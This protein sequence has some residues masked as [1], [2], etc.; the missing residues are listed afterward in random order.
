MSGRGGGHLRTLSWLPVLCRIATAFAAP[1]ADVLIAGDAAPSGPPAIGVAIHYTLPSDGPLPATF[2]VTLAITDAHDADWVVS[3]FVRGATRTVTAE[4]K[5]E[6]TEI[7]DGLDENLM[8]VPPGSYGV[9]GIRM[10]ARRWAPDGDYHTL[11][12]RYLGGP[13]SF[14]PSAAEADKPPKVHGD[15]VGSV[16]GAISTPQDWSAHATFYWHYLENGQNTYQ[17]DLAKPVGYGQISGSYGSGGAGGGSACCTDGEMTWSLNEDGPIPYLYRA[18]AKPFGHGAGHVRRNVWVTRGQLRGLTCWRE[19]GATTVYA[20]MGAENLIKDGHPIN[21]P[22]SG[23]VDA[24]VAL[25]GA[26]AAELVSVPLPAPL[27]LTAHNRRLYALHAVSDGF[28]IS[29]IALVAGLPSGGWQQLMHLSGIAQPCDLALD[30]QGSFYV[31]DTAANQVYKLATDGSISLRFGHQASYHGRYDERSFLAPTKLACWR[32]AAGADRLLVVEEAGPAR[33]SEWTADGQLARQWTTLQANCNNGVAIDPEH[34]EQLYIPGAAGW[35]TRFRADYAKG[36]WT[37]D[38]VWPQAGVGEQPRMVSWQGHSWLTYSRSSYAI[39]RIDGYDCT[40]AAGVV[41]QDGKDCFWHDADGNGRV[42]AGETAAAAWPP[43][44]RKY[45]GDNWSSQLDLVAIGMGTPDVWILSPAGADARGN[46]VFDGAR[47]RR[48]LTDPVFA[49][50]ANGTSTPIRGGNEQDDRFVSDWA[51]V[52]LLADGEVYVNARGGRSASANNGSQ[53]KL[54]HYLPDGKGGL[55]L[56]WRV[57]RAALLHQ[58]GE[59]EGSIHVWEPA[60]GLV[61]IADQ[62]RAGYHVFTADEGLY[63]DTLGLDG[64]HQLESV[65]ATCGEFFAGQH[66]LNRDDGKV[67]L[68]MGKATPTFFAVDG[69]E[70]DNGIRPLSGLKE[71]VV[72]LAAAHIASPPEIALAVRGGAGTAKVARI[73]PAPGG[74]PATDGSLTG[75]EACPVLGFEHTGES[76]DVRLLYDPDTLYMRAQARLVQPLRAPALLPLEQCF[77]HDRGACTISLYLQGDAQA[78]PGQPE[79]RPGDV[80]LVFG[81]FDDAGTTR[82]I[83]LGLYPRY[84]GPAP[85]NPTTY[86]TPVGRC[87]FAHVG[88]MRDIALTHTV[89]GDGKGFTITAAIPR[90]VLPREISSFSGLRTML[91]VEATLRGHKKFWWAD[92]GSANRETNDA[93]SEARLYPNAWAQAEFAPLD[94]LVL[95]SWLVCGPFGGPGAK[96]F[97]EDLP[98][99]KKDE[100]DRFF[101][102]ASYPPDGGRVDPAAVFSGPLVQGYW[103]DPG[104]VRW[105]LRTT[106]GADERIALA[107]GGQVW[108]AAAWLHVDHALSVDAILF[109]HQQTTAHWLLNGAALHLGPA[110]GEEPSSATTLA[111]TAGWNQLFVRAHCVGY[112]PFRLGCA[113]SGAPAALWSIRTAATPPP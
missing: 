23:R 89:A 27:A 78:G 70:K 111:L 35:L 75:W 104:Q 36:S 71:R 98:G 13:C 43:G 67:Y 41:K 12:L 81:I 83:A 50:R 101:A 73:L 74:G 93:P 30:A 34:P 15:P 2:R 68:A 17:I 45:W 80:R 69:W 108:Y 40:A 86:A 24:V 3:T 8:P 105:Q 76:L 95:R 52:Q 58:P 18:D 21:Q 79:G 60:Y 37:V 55:T 109:S 106:A 6:F 33:V 56:K 61:G 22:G 31:S 39:W 10:P 25:N 96:G 1:L 62:S 102:A 48:L 66:F 42:D 112:P 100:A 103:R 44:T 4:N 46:P 38:A 54:S 53:E 90:R 77:I 91:D 29:A 5:G 32:D 20:A 26:D 47:W 49:A 87:A 19:N 107:P 82:P 85:A 92:D 59:I 99:A 7:W 63:V 9:K 16:V 88:L 14:L 97:S 28:A 113:L 57:G 64:S 65:Y 94:R 51:K 110:S 84:D 11:S 72:S